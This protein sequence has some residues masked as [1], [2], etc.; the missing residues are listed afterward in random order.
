MSQRINKI[1]K[2]FLEIEIPTKKYTI[3]VKSISV[4]V[5]YLDV[6]I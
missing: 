1:S 4:Y 6:S 3:F 2:N 5:R